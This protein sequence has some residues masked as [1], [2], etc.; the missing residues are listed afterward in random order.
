MTEKRFYKTESTIEKYRIYDE[1][2]EDAY[3][4][5]CDEYTVDSIVDLLNKQEQTIKMLDKEVSAC[6]D[7]IH[8]LEQ[9]NIRLRKN[10]KP[11][12]FDD[13]YCEYYS[14]EYN[15]ETIDDIRFKERTEQ[16]LKKVEKEDSK[17]MTVDEFEKELEKW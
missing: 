12:I 3:F 1:D 5:S 11:S 14:K 4:I 7:T 17:G 15:C 16:A 8:E 2:K 10:Q 9:E 13:N 6:Y